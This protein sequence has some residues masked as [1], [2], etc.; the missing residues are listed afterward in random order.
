[1]ATNFYFQ[2]GIPMGRRSEQNLYEDLIIEA[3]KMYGFDTYYIPRETVNEDNILNE[4]TVQKYTHAYP[5]EMYLENVDGWDGEGE[6]LTKFGL[7]IRNTAT[8]VV[9]RRRWGEIIGQSGASVLPNRPAEGDLIYFPLTKSFLE[10]KKVDANDPFF[11]A[12]K[13]YVFKLQCELMQ[14]SSEVVDTG[15]SEIDTITDNLTLDISSHQVVLETGELFLLEFSTPSSLILE[16]YAV[17][18]N[19]KNADN[20]FYDSGIRDI[21]DFS[22]RNPFGEIFK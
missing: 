9:A 14:F 12:G 2:S 11:Q 15:V 7:E 5:I 17:T 16:D 21:L 1:M 3:L 20:E 8:L 18:T 19:D 6:L 4:D 22:E 13:L 10:I